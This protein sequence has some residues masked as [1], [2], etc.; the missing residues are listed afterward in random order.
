MTTPTSLHYSPCTHWPGVPATGVV[1]RAGLVHF[2]WAD[3]C[4]ATPG[5]FLDTP[6]HV[7]NTRRFQPIQMALPDQVYM[8]LKI[9]VYRLEVYF[10]NRSERLYAGM[11]L[12][13]VR[14]PHY[15]LTGVKAGVTFWD[16]PFSSVPVAQ[17][18]RNDAFLASVKRRLI[19]IVLEWGAV[20]HQ[21]SP[22]FLGVYVVRSCSDESPLDG[23]LESSWWG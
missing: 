4:R 19:D 2:P 6:L 5:L 8:D 18:L 7:E 13:E 3:T 1:R 22:S 10:P 9:C 14:T 16:E 12:E 11:K 17:E 15:V 21:V 20:A 23:F